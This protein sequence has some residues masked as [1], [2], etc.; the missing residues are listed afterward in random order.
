MADQFDPYREALI[1][2]VETQWPEEYDDW[3][4]G[5]RARVERLLHQSPDQAS[6][7]EY[8]RTHTGFCRRI[9]V[10]PEDIAR[11]RRVAK[12]TSLGVGI[13]LS[14]SLLVSVS[15]AS[16]QQL[17][18]CDWLANE[19]GSRQPRPAKLRHRD[20][21]RQPARSRQVLRCRA[22]R[23]A[24]RHHH[25]F[26]RRSALHRADRRC[27]A[28]GRLQTD[29]LVVEAGEQSKAS[30]VAADLW[31]QLLDQG[32][33]RKTVI[34]ALGGG[35]VGDLAGFVAA[36]FTRGLR[37]VQIPTTLLAQV[38]SSV[39]GKVGINLPG[40][41][42][43]VGAFWQPR[44]VLIDVDVLAIAAGARISRRAGRGRQIRRDSGRRVLRLPGSK[45]R[46]ASTP[47]RPPC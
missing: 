30:D 6:Q 16:R 9:V 3:E 24:R 14:P 21:Q 38:D 17:N 43:M 22:G 8:V 2:E 10:T 35:V 34:V 25:R 13:S 37:F 5:E 42:N 27:T 40:G 4:P 32:A 1:V 20:R 12:M 19:N 11:I 47:A 45:R 28:R 23:C 7:L 46:K 18:N 36:T 41:K 44:G 29:I 26:E 33:D 31:E 15:F 39:G